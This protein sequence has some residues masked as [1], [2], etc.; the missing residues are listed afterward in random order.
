MGQRVLGQCVNRSWVNA[1][2]IMGQ[3]IIARSM[4]HGSNEAWV[5]GSMSV[6]QWV[7][8]SWMKWIIGHGS[9][10]NVPFG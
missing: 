8:R 2:V 6:G 7:N 10:G 1:S 9:T 4:G 5:R 3:Q